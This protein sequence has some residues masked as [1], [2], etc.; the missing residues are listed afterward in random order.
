MLLKTDTTL[1]LRARARLETV[2]MQNGTRRIPFAGG[3]INL[4]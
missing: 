4:K 1:R 2:E 3:R